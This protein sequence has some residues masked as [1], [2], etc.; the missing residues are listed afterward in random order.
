M[1]GTFIDNFKAR[2]AEFCVTEEAGSKKK[3]A[4]G[5]GDLDC[6]EAFKRK[7]KGEYA[8]PSSI[9]TLDSDITPPMAPTTLEFDVSP[10]TMEVKDAKKVTPVPKSWRSPRAQVLR[11]R[12]PTSSV[13]SKVDKSH[14]DGGGESE[15]VPENIGSDV[16]GG[17]PND[18]LLKE[19][20]KQ[21]MQA[22]RE[23]ALQRTQAKIEKDFRCARAR[24]KTLESFI[25]EIDLAEDCEGADVGMIDLNSMATFSLSQRSQVICTWARPVMRR[26]WRSTGGSA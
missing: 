20:I 24:G 14:N 15:E 6:I 8:T 13:S 17:R 26:A 12:S 16:V 4:D 11:Y 3:G 2:V 22:P 25:R 18:E 7:A 5:D 21:A 23:R 10:S 9:V 19:V 1:D